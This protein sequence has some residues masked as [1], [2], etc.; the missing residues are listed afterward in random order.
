M[1]YLRVLSF[2][3]FLFSILSCSDK[4][5]GTRPSAISGQV[6]YA[7]TGDPA[8]GAAGAEVYLFSMRFGFFQ[9]IERA[10]TNRRGWFHFGGLAEGPY[11]IYAG[12]RTDPVAPSFELVSPLSGP[13]NVDGQNQFSAGDIILYGV[14]SQSFLAG[15]VV[16]ES[17][18]MPADSVDVVLYSL[19]G[20]HFVA[21]DSVLTDNSGQY[22]F[23]KVRSGNYYIYACKMPEGSLMDECGIF[24]CNGVESYAIDVLEL[25]P[26]P[27]RKPAIYIYPKE[28][29]YFQV[30]LDLNNGTVLTKSVPEYGD[31]WDVLVEKSGKI[32]HQYEYLFYEASLGR[33]PEL[34]RG[35]C[36]SLDH[37]ATELHSLLMQIGLNEK[38]TEEFLEYW[39]DLLVRFEYY[40]VFPVFDRSLDD[41]VELHIMPEPDAMLRFWL[42]FRGCDAYTSPPAPELPDFQRGPTTVVE[43]GGVLLN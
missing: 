16:Y 18:G 19:F 22:S 35:W 13:I 29:A 4:L 7:G 14:Y 1:K 40:M 24:Y 5:T 26:Q 12:E 3:L 11:F 36:I 32:D 39:L 27:V 21:A 2:V 34:S 25:A 20:E 43:W 33:I 17:T 10:E 41:M 37:A 28:D 31:G 6:L 8:T 23:A 30:R 9:F 42:F 38:E 15:D